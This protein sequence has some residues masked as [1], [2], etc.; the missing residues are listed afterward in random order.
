[1][2]SDL[3]QPIAQFGVAGLM[4]LLW[5]WE[6]SMSRKREVQLNEAHCRL[7]S[8][9]DELCTL[10]KLVRQNTRAI[11]RF[12]QTQNQLKALLEKMHNESTHRTA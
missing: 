9:Q 1:M 3:L 6:R 8:Q 2:T 11:V 4:G 12:D 10:V 7:M 5:V